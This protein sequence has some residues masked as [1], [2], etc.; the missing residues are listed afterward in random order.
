MA[1]GQ[2]P[3]SIAKSEPLPAQPLGIAQSEPELGIAKSEPLTD[4]QSGG[5]TAKPGES[6]ADVA[7]RAE[8]AG[9]ES[10]NAPSALGGPT[11][12]KGPIPEVVGTLGW[13]AGDEFLTAS[14]G[15]LLKVAKNVPGLLRVI[16]DHPIA[17]KI[18]LEGG[19]GAGLGAA[20]GAAEANAEG[21]DTLA[22]AKTGAETG[23]VVGGALGAFEGVAGSEIAQKF[24]NKSLGVSA[25]DVTY[26]NPGRALF[27][28]GI[29]NPRTGSLAKFN[30]ALRQGQS[31]DQA[32]QAAGGRM[33]QVSS[34]LTQ[35]NGE[36]DQVLA[37]SPAK[38][39]VNQTILRPL[40]QASV[41]VANNAMIEPNVAQAVEK[42]LDEWANRIKTLVGNK[43]LSPTEVVG[44]KRQLGETLNF[45]RNAAVDDVID[46]VKKELYG[47]M[48]SAVHNA[49]PE[50]GELDR[51]S[52]NLMA[53]W[54][55]LNPRSPSGL[56]AQELA[57]G[58][59]GVEAGNMW[60][61]PQR[62]IAEIG[63]ILPAARET[64]GALRAPTAAGITGEE[65]PTLPEE[66]NLPP[67]EAG[68]VRFN[69][70]DGSIHDVPQDQLEAARK[71][72]PD[73][74][75][76]SAVPQTLAK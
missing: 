74:K 38:I 48:N 9:V 58:G 15:R 46:S 44:L 51:R 40:R 64:V 71:I 32:L 36:L 18:L 19:K 55:K 8:A 73:L 37:N 61:I 60:D 1:D 54:K 75:V 34:R 14:V 39:D 42:V 35:I 72:D 66:Q 22:G 6:L 4:D 59:R 16:E 13:M 31:F 62:V 17:A 30:E 43:P 41:D 57:G 28:E 33:G 49:V 67:V 69:A 24:V 27:E 20:T 21:K 76:V 2:A 10:V 52:T 3:L 11:I 5:V 47:S 12:T 45:T 25:K 29:I 63:R 65:V 70:S 50:A 56:P 26:G 53:A 7:Q 68:Y 23:G